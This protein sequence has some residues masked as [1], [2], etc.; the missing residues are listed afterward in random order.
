MLYN[1]KITL[2]NIVH[3]LLRDI[4]LRYLGLYIVVSLFYCEQEIFNKD[5]KLNRIIQNIGKNSLAIYLLQYFFMPD[6]SG[7]SQ[8][9]KSLDE[10]SIYAISYGYTVFITALC[11]LFIYLLSN[12]K[13]IKKY[14]LGKK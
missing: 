13:F 1:I 7:Y 14:A 2:P 8:W 12:S 10:L 3:H 6:F 9:L 11:M 4:V 5:N